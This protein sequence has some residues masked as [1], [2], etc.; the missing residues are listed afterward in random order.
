MFLLVI[1]Y[2]ALSFGV[3]IIYYRLYS[4]LIVKFNK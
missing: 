4:H 2:V 3:S 1:I